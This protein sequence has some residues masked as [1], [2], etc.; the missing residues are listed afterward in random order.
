MSCLRDVAIKEPLVDVVDQKMVV[1]S[2]CQLL[3]IDLNTM[4]KQDLNFDVPFRVVARHDDYIHAV[5]TYF[6]VEFSKCHKRTWF[7]TAPEA[8]YTHWKQ[9]VFYLHD[10]ATVKKGEEVTGRFSL[11]QNSRN[12]RDLD[13]SVQIDFEGELGS[14]HEKNSYRMR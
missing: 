9:T 2:Q 5:V 3:E 7:S 12:N 1:T 10:Y 13:F 6:T 4:T 8:P 11:K 14:L